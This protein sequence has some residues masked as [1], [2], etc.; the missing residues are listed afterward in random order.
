[1]RPWYKPKATA[2]TKGGGA[3]RQNRQSAFGSE[4]TALA[5]ISRVSPQ[6]AQAGSSWDRTSIQQDEQIGTE[7]RRGRGESQREQTAGRK[8]QL[9]ESTVL[10]S[11]RDTA[12]HLEVSKG[13]TSN[14]SEPESLSKTHLNWGGGFEARPCGQYTRMRPPIPLAGSK[15]WVKHWVPAAGL[16]GQAGH[17]R[18]G[19]SG[20]FCAWRSFREVRNFSYM[21]CS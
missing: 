9:T 18:G 21:A 7:E 15:S 10:R 13:G 5:G 20:G 16:C 19:A 8:A 3:R 12:R 11:T 17:H 4:F 1:M 14:V 6:R 2:R